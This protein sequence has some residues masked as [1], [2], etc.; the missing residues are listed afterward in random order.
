MKPKLHQYLQDAKGRPSSK[1]LMSWV[2]MWFFFIMNGLIIFSVFYTP[3]KLDLQT[4]MFIL[5]LNFLWLLAIFAPTQLSKIQ[6]VKEIIE[7]AKLEGKKDDKS[8]Q[9]A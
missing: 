5:I 6:E 1:R 9:H 3:Q 4:L 2:F 8:G 7:L